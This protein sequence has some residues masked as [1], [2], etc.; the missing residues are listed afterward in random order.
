M[1]ILIGVIALAVLV[2][3]AFG[4]NAARMLVG[5]ILALGSMAVLAFVGSIAIDLMRPEPVK[6][7]RMGAPTTYT[8]EQWSNAAKLGLTPMDCPNRPGYGTHCTD[9]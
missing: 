8:A 6:A 4:P 1:H 5:V 3:F 7:V 9:E 2:G